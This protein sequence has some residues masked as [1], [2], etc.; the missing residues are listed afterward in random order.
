M[1]GLSIAIRLNEQSHAA[2]YGHPEN[3]VRLSGIAAELEGL[4]ASGRATQLVCNEH[5][6]DP[7]TR[8]HDESYIVSLREICRR[9]PG[10]LEPD[11]YVSS[12]SYDAALSMVN[13]TLS[14]IDCVF[15]G[16]SRHVFVHGRPPGHHSEQTH[17]MGFC[18]INN[19]AVGAQYAIDHCSAK[20]VA[21]VD[22]DVHH[23]NGTQHTFYER[24]DVFFVSSHRYPF[25]PGS[26]SAD[27]TG[28]GDGKGY[29][30]NIPLPAGTGDDEFVGGYEK[31]VLSAL[32]RFQP[33]VIL[34]SAGFDACY[35]DPLGGMK[36]TGDGFRRIGSL[37]R[38]TADRVCGGRIVSV[39]EGGYDGQG[40][41]ESIMQYLD[42]I[43][44][45]Q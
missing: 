28:E 16:D 35:C 19:V 22:F 33:D 7:I 26:G 11:T 38:G 20:R 13:A 40:N 34:V 14:G 42:G 25:Y 17:A 2:P 6:V 44:Y 24:Q 39:L 45:D 43:G 15:R 10:Y 37:L 36:V 21:I 9:G 29:T 32:E 3:A 41:R 1:A 12:G 23:G 31:G 8:V 18:L 5:G 27:E 4:T 30:I